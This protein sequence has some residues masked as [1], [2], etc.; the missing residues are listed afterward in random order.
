VGTRT[1]DGSATGLDPIALSVLITLLAVP[2]TVLGNEGA[3]RFGR[4]HSISTVMSASGVVALV[5]AWLVAAPPAVLLVLLLIYAFTLPGD[6]GA[7][8]SGMAMSATPADR[9]ATMALQSMI[10][11][12]V[13]A[14]GGAAVGLAIDAAGGPASDS[15]WT[16]AFVVMGLGIMLGPVALRWST[17]ATRN[18]AAP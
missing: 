16:A 11:F 6:S 13:A 2:A 18:S 3:L 12:G 9:G 14:L 8:T 4:H 5:I 7:L 15:G 10:G 17:C 1:G